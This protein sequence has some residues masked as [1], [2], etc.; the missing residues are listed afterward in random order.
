VLEAIDVDKDVDGFHLYN[1]V[2]LV[3]DVDF[4]GVKEKASWITLVPGGRKRSPQG[5]IARPIFHHCQAPPFRSCQF[6]TRISPAAAPS[7]SSRTRTLA[8]P[9]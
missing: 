5:R 8:R 7:R 3:G 6:P 9:R 2:A 4:E 1:V